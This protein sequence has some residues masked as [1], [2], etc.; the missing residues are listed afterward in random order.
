[1]SAER[2]SVTM[3]IKCQGSGAQRQQRV[4]LFDGAGDRWEKSHEMGLKKNRL[5]FT[6][7]LWPLGILY[8]I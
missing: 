2:V 5:E 6:L 3:V 7:Q 4:V 8:S 1:M